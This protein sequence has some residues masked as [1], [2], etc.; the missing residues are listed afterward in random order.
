MKKNEPAKLPQLDAAVK[1]RID[2]GYEF[3]KYAEQLFNGAVKIGFAD[4]NENHST[5]RRTA[6]AWLEGARCVINQFGLY[7]LTS[8]TFPLGS[9]Q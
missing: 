7:W 1:E 6:E 9:R 3:E 4:F 5:L 2:A 8:I